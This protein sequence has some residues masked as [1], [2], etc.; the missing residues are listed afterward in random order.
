MSAARGHLDE[1]NVLRM[2]TAA[3]VLCIAVLAA[4][5]LLQP[6]LELPER[7]ARDYN[8]GWNALQAERLTRGEVLYPAYDALIGNNYPPLSFLVVAVAGAFVGDYLITGRLIALISL[9]AIAAAVGS[10]VLTATRSWLAALAVGCALIAYMGAHHHW[11]VGINDPQWLGHALMLL[12]MACLIRARTPGILL[13]SAV[14]LM[15]SGGFVKHS[16]LPLPIATT[17]WILMARREWIAHWLVSA[18]LLTG[19]GLAVAYLLFGEAFIQQV[20]LDARTYSGGS[21]FRGIDRHFTPLM[22]IL[23][24]GVLALPRLW[25]SDIGRLIILYGVLSILWGGFML[26]GEGVDRNAVFDIV[27]ALMM[28]IGFLFNTIGSNDPAPQATANPHP[29]LVVL[30]LIIAIAP[31]VPS[32]FLD[33]RA[34]IRNIESNRETAEADIS[35][36]KDQE[37]PVACENLALCYWA[38]KDFEFDHFLTGQKVKTGVI[39][40]DAA[41]EGFSTQRY[42]IVQ[43]D[44]I[45]G[46][47]FRLPREVLESLTAHYEVVHQNPI[48]GLF[49]RP[50]Q[51]P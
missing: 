48:N 9:I 13:Y 5:L 20:F 4:F 36:L 24:L 44:S 11:Y 35:F 46:T 1:A 33:L 19:A 22:P 31:P 23:V 8:E 14:F 41:T 45:R 50:K 2:L 40:M 18:S 12:G 34:Y 21:L 3:G 25:A 28:A 43:L 7:I 32:R 38:G 49:Y 16:L 29:L 42:T 37:G 26:G 39:S 15:V 10:I 17:V 27:I 30:C 47:S 6:V 51:S